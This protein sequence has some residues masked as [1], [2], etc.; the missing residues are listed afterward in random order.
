MAVRV[1]RVKYSR[2]LK[3][4]RQIGNPGQCGFQGFGA[5]FANAGGRKTAAAGLDHMVHDG[6]V[7]G[8]GVVE[9]QLREFLDQGGDVIFLDAGHRAWRAA[10]AVPTPS[11]AAPY[12]FQ[13]AELDTGAFAG[14]E[15]PELLEGGCHFCGCL[16]CPLLRIYAPG[17]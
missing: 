14:N 10:F 15:G 1:A 17:I 12:L 2:E 6:R 3:Q 7:G 5:G 9:D 11:D 8:M 4:G 13:N 16:R